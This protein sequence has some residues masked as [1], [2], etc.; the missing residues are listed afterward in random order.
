[1]SS[2]NEGCLSIPDIRG[3]VKDLTQLK[4]N[5]MIK[6]LIFILKILMVYFQE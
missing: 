4:L 2:F 6:I 5:S 3:D 1:M